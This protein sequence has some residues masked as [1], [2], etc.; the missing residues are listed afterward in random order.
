[1][2]R[3]TLRFALSVAAMPLAAQQS[4][5]ARYAPDGMVAV[6][7]STALRQGRGRTLA[8]FLAGRVP[9]LIVAYESGQPSSAPHITTRGSYGTIAPTE[10]FLYVDGVLW[11]D[12]PNWS[13]IDRT[14]TLPGFGWQMLV[15]EIEEVRVHLGAASGTMLEFGASRGVVEIV[16]RRP[17]D[18]RSIVHAS[19]QVSGQTYE[20]DAMRIVS[21]SVAGNPNS[22]GCTLGHEAD[23]DCTP[24]QTYSV[25][26]FDIDPMYR[27]AGGIDAHVEGLGELLG[28]RYRAA[29]TRSDLAGTL[30]WSGRSMSTVAL[31]LDRAFGS[32]LRATIDARAG[33]F[34]FGV[35][36]R[37]LYRFVEYPLGSRASMPDSTSYYSTRQRQLVRWV[38]PGRTGDR[39]TLGGRVQYRIG[40]A[41]Q[42]A[43]VASLDR[44]WRGYQDSMDLGAPTRK[45]DR[46]SM[47][48]VHVGL[49]AEHRHSFSR[50]VHA[51]F[52]ASAGVTNSDLF[53]RERE[54]TYVDWFGWMSG[55]MTIIADMRQQSALGGVRLRVGDRLTLAGSVRHEAADSLTIAPSLQSASGEYTLRVPRSA[56]DIGV[57]LFGGYGESIDHRTFGAILENWGTPSQA[58]H[59]IERELGLR[60]TR[61]SRVDGSLAHS[62][63]AVSDGLL[64]R[65]IPVGFP[66]T[67]LVGILDDAS[68]RVDATTLIVQL[69]SAPERARDWRLAFSVMRRDHVAMQTGYSEFIDGEEYP[70]SLRT[71]SGS[72]LDEIVSTSY[73]YSD[74][75]D[76][77]I[78]A[79]SEIV[80]GSSFEV[81]GHAEPRTILTFGGELATWR[82]V[83]VGTVVEARLGQRALDRFGFIQCAA[84]NCATLYDS[85]ASLREQAKAMAGARGIGVD[86][87]H[88]ASFARIRELYVEAAPTFLRG[89]RVRLAAHQLLAWSPFPGADPE[90]RPRYGSVSGGTVH[91]SQPL[92]PSVSLRIDLDR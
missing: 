5:I 55:G 89:A 10:P 84:R 13:G 62:R 19:V 47:T 56:A 85:T 7:D 43:L 46:F 18:G 9:G 36:D 32:R 74:T 1:M 44:A 63:T 37:S 60:F 70:V 72:P 45:S 15:D 25:S 17:R 29:A 87:V 4:D 11:R 75:N 61:G 82:G 8:D 67:Y 65:P 34:A 41:T 54:E 48:T 50:S 51:D 90:A 83:R 42:L 28:V 81:V 66:T 77:G 27:S 64:R 3:L 39:A 23:G 12:D 79:P 53:E 88:D 78:I 58:E 20:P 30:Q 21:R 31:S 22:L 2:T 35:A 69:R 49:S 91:R 71:Q 26:A 86:Y 24:G 76:D 40:R 80:M 59:T 73:T 14:W 38:S 57:T 52:F 6:L 68:W 92:Y 33:S 16:T